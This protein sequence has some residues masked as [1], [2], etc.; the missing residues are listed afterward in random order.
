[1]WDDGE[2]RIGTVV[3]V[4]YGVLMFGLGAISMRLFLKLF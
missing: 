1:M 3:G 4:I 2:K